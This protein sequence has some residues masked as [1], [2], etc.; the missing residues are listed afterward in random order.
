MGALFRPFHSETARA[1]QFPLEPIE[2]AALII[3]PPF[4]ASDK[5]SLAAHT[6]QACARLRQL[7]VQVFYANLSFAALIGEDA[8]SAIVESM[9][10]I[11]DF[12]FATAAD[13]IPPDKVEERLPRVVECLGVQADGEVDC[14]VLKDIA[15]S[16]CSWA[17][18]LAT[19]VARG[20]WQVVGCTSSFDQTLAS[21]ALL[22]RIKTICPQ[23]ITVIGGPN[24]DGELA[25][26]VAALHGD[27]DFVF[28]GEGEE[29]FPDFLQASASG[30][31]PDRRV[32]HGRDC[33]NLDLIPPPDYREYL[34]QRKTYLPTP[35]DESGHLW[36]TYE[37][38]R[39]CWWA[40]GKTCTFCGQNGSRLKC[41]EKSPNK[42][43][44]DLKQV[45]ASS[46]TRRVFMVDSLMPFSYFR[47]L[48][49]RIK[50]EI[51]DISVFYEL[52]ADLSL[53]QVL[54][55]HAAGVRSVQVGI[56]SLSSPLLRRM[57]KGVSAAQNIALLRYCRA[58]EVSVGWLLLHG[59]PGDLAEDYEQT[60]ALLPLLHHLQPPLD[61]WPV[62]IAR[63]S[64]YFRTPEKFGVGN[65]R[66]LRIYQYSYPAEADVYRIASHFQADYESY[67]HER[68]GVVEE[69]RRQVAS[70]RR[71][72]FTDKAPP[73]LRLRR[74]SKN[75]FALVDTRNVSSSPT[76]RLVNK[77]RATTL[78]VS[79]RS[80]VTRQIAWATRQ[81]LG[82]ILDG[83]W[84]PL[85]VADPEVIRE[86]E[87]E[88][89]KNEGP[90][91][92][93]QGLKEGQHEIPT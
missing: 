51:P 81:K 37:T 64:P 42:V 87:A 6:L 3:V 88:A 39:G 17:D 61:V 27:I 46:P 40:K 31:L 45:F 53:D 23:V 2:G 22:R 13:Q 49:P 89:R 57:G 26:G 75:F 35:G 76:I 16:A 92:R 1:S 41:R 79:T 24:C 18:S 54:R 77:K 82:L 93:S 62:T 58:V 91:A 29:S 83:C 25:R 43:L 33:A 70:W 72:W 69:M 34:Q 90:E 66:P 32:I 28:S 80:P 30:Q 65:I 14:Q 38:S 10:L 73:S 48:L 52:R 59:F 5:P 84:V 8:Y 19:A 55:L 63:F 56:E 20:R 68:P 67:A 12:L 78:L 47:T 74:V 36:L 7:Q 60:L 11:G 15:S 4:A 21:V 9:G 86:L 50:T 71:K 85:V 44:S